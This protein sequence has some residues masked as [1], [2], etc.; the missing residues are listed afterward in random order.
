MLVAQRI[1]E[2]GHASVPSFHRKPEPYHT[3]A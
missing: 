3:I 2:F 1:E